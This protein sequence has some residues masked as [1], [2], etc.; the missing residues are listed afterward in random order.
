MVKHLEHDERVS[1]TLCDVLETCFKN[2]CDQV[3]V[4][5]LGV[6]LYEFLA[7]EPPFMGEGNEETYKLI[8]RGLVALPR[9]F[10]E[11]VQ[12]LMR[13]LLRINPRDRISLEE[14]LTHPWIRQHCPADQDEH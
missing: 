11:G 14:V 1:I 5:T 12:D 7:G 6:L 3:D 4:W 13:K 2:N 8:N 10:S 9:Y